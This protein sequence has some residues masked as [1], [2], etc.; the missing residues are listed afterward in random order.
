MRQHAIEVGSEN[1]SDLIVEPETVFFSATIPGSSEGKY[2]LSFSED[3]SWTWNGSV[4]ISSAKSVGEFHS[5]AA[6]HG[7][8]VIESF[9]AMVFQSKRNDQGVVETEQRSAFDLTDF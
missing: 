5:H 7:I 8:E 2:G 4:V 1:V 9:A 3:R 6:S